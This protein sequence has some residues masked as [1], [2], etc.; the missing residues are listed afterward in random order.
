M[1]KR[2]FVVAM[3]L[4][5]AFS[6][7]FT[8]SQNNSNF[9]TYQSVGLQTD[10]LANT[11]GFNNYLEAKGIS[12][13]KSF[14]PTVGISY[15]AMRG[16]KSKIFYG[17]S[18]SFSYGRAET[19]DK[20]LKKEDA[21]VHADVFY[22]FGLGKSVGLEAGVGFGLSYSDIL[23]ACNNEQVGSFSGFVPIMPITAGI[24]F[25]HDNPNSV[26]IYL[27]YIVSFKGDNSIHETGTNNSISGY[28][29]R[30]STLSVG[31]KFGF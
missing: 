10:L 28:E 3:L 9:Q 8:F 20:F 29:L 31:V 7:Q 23:Y 27:Q 12:T 24:V 26:G 30:P 14:V 5:F 4:C 17:V 6:I 18:A 2:S 13:F 1:K 15:S 22:R 21:S 19:K 25:P 11:Q 16:Y